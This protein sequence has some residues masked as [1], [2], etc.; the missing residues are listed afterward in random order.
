MNTQHVI[1]D[2]LSGN[3]LAINPQELLNMVQ[4]QL[5]HVIDM[6]NQIATQSSMLYQEVKQCQVLLEQLKL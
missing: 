6:N 4:A 1:K 2:T 5:R 3:E